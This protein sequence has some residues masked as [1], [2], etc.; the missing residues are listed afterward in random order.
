MEWF[1]R[2]AAERTGQPG[3]IIEGRKAISRGGKSWRAR[4]A[5]QRAP[6]GDIADQ[7]G[8]IEPLARPNARTSEFEFAHDMS[9]NNAQEPPFLTCVF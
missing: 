1:R 5:G 7:Y 4:T 2:P 9:P 6:V 8:W 3:P